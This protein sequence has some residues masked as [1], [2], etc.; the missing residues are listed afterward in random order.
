MQ[1][2]ERKYLLSGLPAVNWNYHK[3]IKQIY[4]L[5]GKSTIVRARSIGDEYFITMKSSGQDGAERKEFEDPLS[6]IMFDL[7][8]EEDCPKVIKT[9]H[10]FNFESNGLKWLETDVYHGVL[11]GLFTAEVEFK[12]RKEFDNF[13]VPDFL[14]NS[15]AKDVTFDSKYKN[16]N[17]AGVLHPDYTKQLLPVK[18]S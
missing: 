8:W 12:G 5:D 6:Q 2:I 10:F 16:N 3:E 11:E 13:Q 9:R 1:E 4:I 17:L 18:R 7:V 14:K 15:F